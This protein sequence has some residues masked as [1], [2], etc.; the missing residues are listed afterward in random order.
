MAEKRIE[1]FSWLGAVGGASARGHVSLL[2]MLLG[3]SLRSIRRIWGHGAQKAK[4]VVELSDAFVSPL[5]PF[6]GVRQSLTHGL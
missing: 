5:S 2:Q 4:I 3:G 6:V 1:G